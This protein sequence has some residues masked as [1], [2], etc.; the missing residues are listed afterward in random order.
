[1]CQPSKQRYTV[2][3]CSG[4]E[5]ISLSSRTSHT[6]YFFNFI[7][8]FNSDSVPPHSLSLRS[9][10]PF[11]SLLGI[12]WSGISGCPLIEAILGLGFPV[13]QSSSIPVPHPFPSIFKLLA[14]PIVSTSSPPSFLRPIDPF[15]VKYVFDFL[16][17]F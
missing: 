2:P 13:F 16:E 10:F 7:C 1:M 5:V 9:F 6:F 15:F 12:R 8:I 4:R 3:P 14:S 11:Q 17:E